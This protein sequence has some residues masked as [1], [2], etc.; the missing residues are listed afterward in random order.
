MTNPA[1][2][3]G[4]LTVAF[5]MTGGRQKGTPTRTSRSKRPCRRNWR[6][7]AL[8][9]RRCARWAADKAPPL[10]ESACG[11]KR[12]KTMSALMSAIGGKADSMRSL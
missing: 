12:R 11:P 5:R 4:D 10:R 7:P 1:V 2:A 6:M 3:L 8:T 9:A